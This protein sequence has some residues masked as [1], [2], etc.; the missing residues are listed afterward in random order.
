MTDTKQRVITVKSSSRFEGTIDE[1][2][3][4][5]SSLK[6]VHWIQLQDAI[7]PLSH[8][9]IDSLNDTLKFQDP[10]QR[11]VTLQHGFYSKNSIISEL[12]NKMD[13]ISSLVFTIDINNINEK[14]TIS[15]TSN[16]SL[17]FDQKKNPA[18]IL[19]YAEV[20]ISGSNSYT[21]INLV[22][23]NRRYQIF[24]Y[25]SKTI[26]ASHQAVHSTDLQN[27]L[28]A[29]AL[30]SSYPPKGFFHYTHD[31]HS[32][33]MI[34]HNSTRRIQTIDIYITDVDGNK[35]DFNGID[36]VVFNFIIFQR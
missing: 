19:G 33:F 1:F 14:M 5:F 27:N 8:Y 16:F 10:V 26:T 22:N 21:G 29:T 7:I 3:A 28:I 31:Q 30:N 18:K 9:M 34:K 20:E 15:S 4:K 12:K 13:A 32:N 36:Q 2:S 24:N 25:Y 23:L 17:N 35:I 11:S 6:N